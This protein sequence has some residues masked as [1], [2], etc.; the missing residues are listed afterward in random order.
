MRLLQIK[1]AGFKS[2]ADPTLIELN[3]PVIG[4]V[5]PNGCGK[6]NIIDA[7]RWVLGE[8]RVGEL[9]GSTSMSELIFQGSTT[10]KPMG[11][12]SVELV[13]D[14]SDQ[15][16]QGP[17]GTYTDL[18]IKRVMT[19]DGTSSYFINNQ[20]VRRRDVQ[21]IFLGTGLGA[22][23]YAII[24][25][26]MIASF[27][28]AKPEEL[29]TYLE[30]AAGVSLY[31][32]RRRET[33]NLLKQTQE[34]LERATDL[35]SVKQEEIARLE[36][37]A[38]VAK[39]WLDLTQQKEES[40][41]LWYFLQ[42]E[43]ARQTVD[44]AQ[45][46]IT[47]I[48]TEL[49]QLKVDLEASTQAREGLQA[50]LIRAEGTYTSAVN[51]V[52]QAERELARLEGENKR[53]VDRRR[54]AE[55]DLAQASQTLQEKNEALSLAKDT[56]ES[57]LEK[58][59]LL[60]EEWYA[61]D[62]EV[63]QHEEQL[64]Q[65]QTL[66]DQAR[67]TMNQHVDVVNQARTQRMVL[68]E[69][70]KREAARLTELRERQARLNAQALQ[71]QT[72]DRSELEAAQEAYEQAQATYEE[73]AI[74]VDDY[75]E[76]AE[77]AREQAH[78]QN[79]TYF[80]T[81]AE[82]KELS[83]KLHTLESIQAGGDQ[84]EALKAWLDAANLEGFPQLSDAMD[85]APQWLT[86][87]EAIL[88]FKTQSYLFRNL[89]TALDMSATRPPVRMAFIG[90][91]GVAAT[92]PATSIDTPE[93]AWPALLSH[94]V[95]DDATA[96]RALQSWLGDV[97]EAPSLKQA[98]KFR[99]LLPA[100]GLF[101][102]ADGDVVSAVSLTYWAADRPELSTLTRRQEIKRLTEQTDMLEVRL[103]DADTARESAK[104]QEAQTRQILESKRSQLQRAQQNVNTTGLA[105][106]DAQAA[107]EAATRQRDDYAKSQAE[108]EA[109]LA[110]KAQEVEVLAA[111]VEEALVRVEDAEEALAKATE[112]MQKAQANT[113]RIRQAYTHTQN[114]MNAKRTERA[115]LKERLSGL[116]ASVASL[117][118]D[119][120]R[121]QARLTQAQ[122]VLNEDSQDDAHQ[123]TQAW[124]ALVQSKE[125]AATQ[126]AE[127]V[128][129][130]RLAVETNASTTRDLQARLMPLMESLSQLK[131]TAESKA[132]LVE[133][134]SLRM[135]ELGK[136]WTQMALIAQQRQVKVT[137]VRN[138]VTRL[139]SEIAALGPVNHAALT[140][141]Q[142]TQRALEATQLQI[143]DLTQA[144]Q[145]L[146]E[147]IKKIDAETRARLKETFDAVNANFL[148][149]FQGLF[150]GG[151]ANLVMTGDE[152]LEAGVEVIAQPPGKRNASVK[153]LS[154]GE[155]AL[156]ATALVF[157][158]FQLNPAPFCLL[159]EVDA[160]L[161]EA[162]QARLAQLC[163]Q[164]SDQTQFI[165]ITHH[166]VTMEFAQA[167]IGVTMKEPGVSRVVS[168][169]IKEAVS[170]SMAQKAATRDDVASDEV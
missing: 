130:A 13:L 143:D 64:E 87:V 28:R 113:Q 39:K 34:N 3:D 91:D 95:T 86:A 98:L 162:N 24:S 89:Q 29:R 50:A 2:F 1:I 49:T 21:E 136:D 106:K 138:E 156:T 102:T 19:R 41:A 9:R 74:E 142:E 148:K 80:T 38:E 111:Q 125:A 76:Q 35:Q 36:S 92:P 6:S 103:E 59:A 22:R 145:T 157:A 8:G 10:R 33:E 141:L 133:Q 60:E 122:A 7:V 127:A 52:R 71:A 25:Q 54:N 114:T 96:L 132:N 83:A 4:I 48:E 77:Q 105:F 116:Q 84:D 93:G 167:L 166:R 85:V 161:D 99:H 151:H 40:E 56:V 137:T 152:I 134:F 124:V 94:V 159:D 150:G 107:F 44:D 163:L 158:M 160:P 165:F 30:E 140:H 100:K 37:E 67:Q 123:S 63:A 135:D 101:V 146:Q 23:S 51:E 69:S 32:E 110:Q 31:K 115:T 45:L 108:I 73:L 147:A 169:D 61:F 120:T 149:T 53:L 18:A 112:G 90:G 97:Y 16:V 164:M 26:G 46:K 70:H 82:I 58:E 75:A 139:M 155:Q 57:L 88:E 43:D 119:I 20:Q 129:E 153:L 65:A 66:E 144:M 17:W 68:E 104:Q 15:T 5:G 126:A 121:E 117:Q 62:E 81:L 154:G 109:E 131:I 55:R 12:A 170:Y 47:T 72:L 168:V 14:N 128:Q 78:T 79:E 118:V 27:I 11:R 42:Y